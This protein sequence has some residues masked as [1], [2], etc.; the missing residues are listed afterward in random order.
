MQERYGIGNVVGK[1]LWHS[2]NENGEIGVYDMKFGNTIVRNLL[3]EDIKTEEEKLHEHL[4]RGED[5]PGRLDEDIS[6]LVDLANDPETMKILAQ[7]FVKL[8]K[9][10]AP[11][12]GG[13]GL[14]ALA[15]K[16]LSQPAPQEDPEG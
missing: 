12:A 16:V 3:A 8:A 6:T 14:I 15:Q 9:N 10:M 5:D 11:V 1:V 4:A 13:A 7:A 2:L